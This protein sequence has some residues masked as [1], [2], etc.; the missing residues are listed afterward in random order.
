[1]RL[2]IDCPAAGARPAGRS[3]WT[4]RR[5]AQGKSSLKRQPPAVTAGPQPRGYSVTTILPRQQI[6]DAVGIDDAQMARSRHP[7][8]T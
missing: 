1:M 2:P 5:G 8:D 3:R 6:G 7:A 4:L